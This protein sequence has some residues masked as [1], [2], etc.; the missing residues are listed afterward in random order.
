MSRFSI[1]DRIV[2]GGSIISKHR[3]RQGTVVGVHPSRHSRPGTT[4]LDK[5][6]VRFDDDEQVQFYDTQLVKIANAD[7]GT[8]QV[9][10]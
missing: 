4:S 3:N 9:A 2:I 6:T 10:T 5:Y 1:G 7:K 8:G